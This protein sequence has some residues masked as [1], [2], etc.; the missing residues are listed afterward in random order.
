MKFSTYLTGFASVAAICSATPLTANAGSTNASIAE[1]FYLVTTN[2]KAYTSNS[3]AL[4]NVSLTTLFAP[5][6]EPNDRLRL[7]GPGYGSVPTFNMSDGVLHC[8]QQGPHGVG[9]EMEYNSTAVHSGSELQFL[10][11]YQGH[12]DL[13][14]K[15]GYLLSVNGSSVGWTIC[16]EELGQSVVSHLSI[17]WPR[18][19][20]LIM[21][22]DRIQGY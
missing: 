15:H 9:P 6:Y 2:Q 18:D 13:S 1:N 21:H 16:V 17:F 7:I 19:G 14:L 11:Q 12:G 4:A 3:S 22:L 5:Y 8:E 10:A 20:L